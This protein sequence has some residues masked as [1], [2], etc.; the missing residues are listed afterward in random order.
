MFFFFFSF[1]VSVCVFFPGGGFFFFF[2]NS[3]GK[4]KIK[5][6]NPPAYQKGSVHDF[7]RV[8]RE[9]KGPCL[10]LVFSAKTCWWFFYYSLLRIIIIIIIFEKSAFDYGFYPSSPKLTPSPSLHHSSEEKKKL[11]RIPPP[12][13]FVWSLEKKKK[14]QLSSNIYHQNIIIKNSVCLSASIIIQPSRFAVYVC[15]TIVQINRLQKISHIN[16]KWF[17]FFIQN[18]TKKQSKTR[19]KEN[20]CETKRKIN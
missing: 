16:L 13:L 19:K 5:K 12:L 14:A 1:L 20:I 7:H 8:L 15:V 11:K 9:T 18:K 17:L 6:K 4:I 2:F 3:V 10:A